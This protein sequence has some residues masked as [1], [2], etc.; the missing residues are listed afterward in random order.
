M[1]PSVSR[2]GKA[3]E[4]FDR[5]SPLL[6]ARRHHPKLRFQ[7]WQE[8]SIC[9]QPNSWARCLIQ[10]QPARNSGA[11]PDGIFAKRSEPYCVLLLD[12][13]RNQTTLRYVPFASIFAS[14]DA[15]T[16]CF[17]LEI[18]SRCVARTVRVLATVPTFAR[19]AQGPRIGG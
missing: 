13:H 10:W 9:A 3:R 12:P 11:R 7:N 2:A 6:R 16:I 17:L 18:T 1:E 8:R 14:A 4:S 15:L 19:Q 5:R